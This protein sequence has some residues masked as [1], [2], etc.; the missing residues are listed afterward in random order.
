MRALVL[1]AAMVFLVAACGGDDDSGGGFF[2]QVGSGDDG[3]FDAGDLDELDAEDI[4]EL[5]DAAATALFG[6]TRLERDAILARAD[7][8][9]QIIHQIQEATA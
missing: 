2:D 7:R 3:G 4:N 1:S 8:N 6:A 9:I 5:A